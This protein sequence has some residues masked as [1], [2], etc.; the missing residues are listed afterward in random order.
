MSG[1]K[2]NI[3]ALPKLRPKAP[4]SAPIKPMPAYDMESSKNVIKVT[5]KPQI[6]S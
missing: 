1:V 6:K 2:L 5:V 3:F 4:M